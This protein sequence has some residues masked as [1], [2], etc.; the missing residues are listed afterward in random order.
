VW[1]FERNSSGANLT[2]LPDCLWWAM[3]TMTTVGYGDHYPVTVGGRMV[4]VAI[5]VIGVAFIGAV[6]TLMAFGLGHRYAQRLEEAV[7]QVQTSVAQAG[8][9]VDLATEAAQAELAAIEEG[10]IGVPDDDSAASLT[11]LLARLG[12]HPVASEDG[13]GWAHAGVRL[14]LQVQPAAGFTGPLTFPSGDRERTARIGREATR[15]GFD[16]S[17]GIEHNQ[18]RLCTPSGFEVALTVSAGAALS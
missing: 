8:A 13:L 10:L 6:A 2:A 7:R 11:W 16:R 9:G 18:V 15:H 5:M 4:A 12:W 14:R 17:G 1:S 3:T